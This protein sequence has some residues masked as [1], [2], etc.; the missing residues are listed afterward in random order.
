MSHRKI[1]YL[2]SQNKWNTSLIKTVTMKFFDSH[3][4]S[5]QSWACSVSFKD[6]SKEKIIL[7]ERFLRQCIKDNLIHQSQLAEAK[8]HI[9]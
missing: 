6:D 8:F 2:N 5:G 4:F 3:G 1:P 7:P 9:N